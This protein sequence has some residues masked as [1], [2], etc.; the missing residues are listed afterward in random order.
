M[1]NRAG[2]TLFIFFVL[3]LIILAQNGA[4][5][6]IFTIFS[7]ATAAPGILNG[8]A[9]PIVTARPLTF[10]GQP[11]SNNAFPTA[12]SP[13]AYMNPVLPTAYAPTYPGQTNGQPAQPG[14]PTGVPVGSI[15]STGQCIAPNGWIAYTI[16]SGDTLAVIAAGYNLTAQ[17]LAAANCMANPDLIYA[18]QVIAVPSR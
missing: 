14:Q 12:Y 8:P 2:L 11:A 13:T 7:G 15:S 3:L 10:G 1:R 18:G 9:G 6:N 4:L 16:Q 5:G 17:D